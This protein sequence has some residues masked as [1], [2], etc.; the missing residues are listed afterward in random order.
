MTL[1]LRAESPGSGTPPRIRPPHLSYLSLTAVTVA[2]AGTACTTSD[3]G[4]PAH[5]PLHNQVA[6]MENIQ[7]QPG[8]RL[9]W[10]GT[11]A[12]SGKLKGKIYNVP[13]RPG[14]LLPIKNMIFVCKL[15]RKL[16]L[17]K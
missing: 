15:F 1:V 17:I 6:A 11:A 14:K 8:L 13:P 2:R 7:Q 3:L 5:E 4:S 10:K 16:V 9:K 12:R